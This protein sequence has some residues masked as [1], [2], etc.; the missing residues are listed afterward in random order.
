MSRRIYRPPFHRQI[1]PWIF[2][3]AFFA[4]APVL[5]FYTSGYRI[6]TKKAVIERTGTLII[7]S[8]PRGAKVVLD[9]NDVGDTTAVTLQ[10]IP[11]GPHAIEVSR[12][13]Y[14]PWKKT[15]NVKPEQVTFANAIWLVRAEDPQFRF[16]LPVISMEA[17]SDRNTLAM[18]SRPSANDATKDAPGE[19]SVT[20]WS[21]TTNV[22]K[23]AT[24]PFQNAPDDIRVEYEPN[25]RSFVLGGDSKEQDAY[26]FSLDGDVLLH[27]ALP[28]GQ[29][30]WDATD[31]IGTDGIQR[32]VWKAQNQSLSRERLA[33]QIIE[34]LD[35][36]TLLAPTGTTSLALQHKDQP[37]T[38]FSL[39]SNDWLFAGTRANHTLLKRDD[40]WMAVSLNKDGFE[41]KTAT[42]KQPVWSN[43][44]ASRGILIHGTEITIWDL[45]QESEVVWRRSEP[46][47]AAAWHRAGDIVFLATEH[48]VL[49]LDL[50]PRDGYMVYQLS[51]F[52]RVHDIAVL[53]QELYIAAEEQGRHGVFVQRV[54]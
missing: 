8:T 34:T 52:D 13:G 46:V 54:E 51:S 38:L 30:Y 31:L 28:A 1:L 15:L 27:E 6:N 41:S 2:A 47:I 37:L 49:A 3:T 18:V 50:D 23:T 16:N 12:N 25:G 39:P 43:R 44:D 32:S 53:N 9:G 11:P 42:G 21:E 36:F 7:D 29:Y 40:D 24:V 48:E 45:D 26:W 22:Q 14:F 20:L 33:D 10:E 17:N 19:V 5:I 4:I 35:S